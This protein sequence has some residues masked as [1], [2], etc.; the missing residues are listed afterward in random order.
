MNIRIGYFLLAGFFAATHAL[1]AQEDSSRASA[2]IDEYVLRVTVNNGE[3]ALKGEAIV[4]LHL[5]RDSVQNIRFSMDPRMTINT[6][7]DAA[8]EKIKVA[9]DTAEQEKN[10]KEFTI[11]LNDSLKQGDSIAVKISYEEAFDT[12]SSLPSFI[13]ERELLLAST[14]STRWWPV[15][16]ASTD[17]IHDQSA[18]VVLE[19]TL[20]SEFTVLSNIEADSSHRAESATTWTFTQR[21]AVPLASCFL[22]CASMDLEEKVFEGADTTVRVS[23]YYNPNRFAPDLAA[24]VALQ[25]D[26]AYSFYKAFTHRHQE[27]TN[28]RM[29]VVGAE[30]DQADW[31]VTQG[32]IIARNS[33]AYTVNDTTVLLSSERSRWVHDVAR[34]FGIAVN[35][36]THWFDAGWFRYLAVKYFLHKTQN[37]PEAQREIRLGVLSKTLDFYPTQSLRQEHP[38]AKNERALYNG[39]GAYIFLMLEYVIGENAMNDVVRA[40]YKDFAESPVTAGAF[41]QI[42]EDAYGSPLGWFFSEWV[43]Q[44]GFPELILSTKVTLTNRGN[45]S[46][47]ATVSQRGDLFITPVDIVLSNDVRSVTKRVFVERQEQEFEFI[48]PFLPTRNEID[49]DYSLLRWVPR[50]R[51]LA[52]ARSSISFRVIDH[53]LAN[54]EREATTFLQLDPNNL[55]GWGNIALFSLGKSA[56]IKGDLQKAEEYFRRASVL[57]ASEPAQLYS[58]LSLVRLGNVL[59]M[60]GKRDEAVAL[61]RLSVTLAK[62]RPALYSIALTDALKYLSEKFVSSEDFWYKEY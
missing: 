8:D 48:L 36:S 20:P 40:L 26:D 21:R 12:L 15:L 43:N 10:I 45:Y 18:P 56:V 14:D 34:M 25:L 23:L 17:P 13:G 5:L 29:A 52:H 28:V 55:T 58:V 42:C 19:A 37:D 46:V 11:P 32:T 50:L 62:R 59:E 27:F 53:D 61:Y 31:L 54:S 44:T 4:H 49:P 33:Y 51:L 30:S 47:R 57:D 35:D 16:S 24:A 2:A 41:Q 9:A 7:R 1:F 60:E 38:V 22:L 39:K 3:H 6:I